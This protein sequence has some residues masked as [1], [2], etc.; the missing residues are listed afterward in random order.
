MPTLPRWRGWTTICFSRR[1]FLRL[2][3]LR[4]EPSLPALLVSAGL[5]LSTHA[6]DGRGQC[7]DTE[8]PSSFTCHPGGGQR[9]DHVTPTHAPP[10][11]GIE[12][13]Q[14][15]RNE[16]RQLL[17]PSTWQMEVFGYCAQPSLKHL[18]IRH[19]DLST[20][21]K[22][23]GRRHGLC[24]SLQN[25]AFLSQKDAEDCRTHT[26]A[27]ADDTHM[28]ARKARHQLDVGQPLKPGH[29]KRCA[30]STSLTDDSAWPPR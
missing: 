20:I 16:S 12:P 26:C 19:V 4:L 11:C 1:W 24:K 17:P 3:C 18:V 29:C 13:P 7:P 10:F 5:L 6:P 22:E 30:F 15:S 23:M 14:M 28:T 21:R 25:S 27:S 8:G 9:P 2:D